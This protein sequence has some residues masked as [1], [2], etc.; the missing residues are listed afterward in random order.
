MLK[1]TRSYEVQI[2]EAV[3][4]VNRALGGTYGTSS[5]IGKTE[6]N[7]YEVQLIDAIK[8][9]GRTLSGKGLSLAGG[10]GAG[11]LSGYA[12]IA[13]FQDLSRRVTILENE[14]FFRLVDGNITLKPQYQNLWVPGWLAAGGVGSGGGGGGGSVE[15]LSDIGDVTIDTTTLADG[16]GI[17]WDATNNVWKNANVGGGG[18][19]SVTS[20][21][22]TVPTGLRV[23]GVPITSSGTIAISY[24]SGY[25]IPTTSK[26]NAWDAKQ[27]A[28]SDLSTIRTNASHGQTAY[29]WGDHSQAGY[30]TSETD[31]TVP[32]WAKATNKP[33]YSFSEITSKPTTLAGYGITDAKFGTP[34]TDNVPITLGSTTTSVLTAHQDLTPLSNRITAIEDWFE[35]VNV[36]TSASPVYALHAKQG[37]AIYSDSW[38][39]AGGIGSGG[40]G[41]GGSAVSWGT[42]SGYTRPLTVEGTTETLLL[43][44][45]LTGYA[46]QSWVNQQGFL[47]SFTETDPTVP[48]WAKASSKPSYSLSE[49]SGTDDLQAIEALSG[50]SGLLRKTGSNTWSLDTTNYL[51][52]HQTIYKLT[53]NSGTFTAGEYTPNSGA[54]TFNVPTTLDHLAD[55]SSR[56]LSD[57][58]TLGTT[59]TITGGKTFSG[60]IV[61]DGADIIPSA[62]LGSQ[63]GYSNRRFS[64]LNVRTIGSVKE[65]NF[66]DSNNSATTGYLSFANGWMM[67]RVGA[68]ID[69][70]YKQIIFHETYGFYPENGSSVNLGYYSSTDDR[71]RWANIY[72]VNEDLSGNLN[73]GGTISVK[74]I[75]S[76][77]QS[78]SSMSL[79]N[80]GARTTK[81][82]DAYGTSITLRAHNAQG[83]Q[84]NLLGVTANGIVVNSTIRPNDI[85]GLNLGANNANGRWA[86][87]YGVNADLSGDLSLAQTS[88]IDIGPARI[89]YDAKN[90]AIHVTTNQAGDNAPAIG[91]YADGFSAA[92]GI[93]SSTG[94]IKYV[95]CS[96]QAE[97]DAI[98]PK[99]SST[100]YTVGN[101]VT[102]I[103]LGTIQLYSEN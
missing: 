45:A 62:D 73:V 52:S 57:Y 92:G 78:N 8:G 20:V 98:S 19:G 26:Q 4:A 72:G 95:S 36:G 99:N 102:K 50:T 11:D 74:S 27:D 49:I 6:F 55:G 84:I 40:G 29:G 14:S 80:Y 65:I 103:Y 88:H 79:F 70:S 38:I 100:I 93:G 76:I 101:P 69:S 35:V 39:A 24:A 37:R 16:Q 44:G 67:L 87:I 56:K 58:V 43:D 23:A 13:Q 28:I 82:F 60:G 59:Q 31:P 7:Q 83:T 51:S 15:H 53:L 21:N 71:F 25:K 5:A 18:S 89:E 75:N 41:G 9:I 47:T 61:M 48:A 33:S 30:L 97:Y 66:K 91:L 96:S 68:D 90:G 17:V 34:G 22:V 46:T 12:T 85:A 2:I 3:R 63:L 77:D 81:S 1:D 86:T 54:K 32:A 10:A 94:T 64:N 42:R